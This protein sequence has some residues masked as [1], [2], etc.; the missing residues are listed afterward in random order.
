MRKLKFL[1]SMNNSAMGS[2][3]FINAVILL[4]NSYFIAD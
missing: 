3:V 1:F 2:G 4:C